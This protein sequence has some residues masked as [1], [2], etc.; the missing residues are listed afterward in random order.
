MSPFDLDDL[1]LQQDHLRRIARAIVGDAYADDVVQ[2]TWAAALARHDR[3]PGHWGSWLNRVT[4]NLAWK[5]RL[6]DERGAARARERAAE[7]PIEAEASD[8]VVAEIE[9]KHVVERAILGLDEPY[10]SVLLWRYYEGLSIEEVSRRAGTN[11]STTRTQLQRGLDRLRARLR[12]KRGPEWRLALVPFLRHEPVAAQATAATVLAGVWT[13]TWMKWSVASVVVAS[14]GVLLSVLSNGPLVPPD[15][16][17]PLVEPEASVLAA[18]DPS[19][20]ESAVVAPSEARDPIAAH[21]PPHERPVAAAAAPAATVEVVEAESGLPLAGVAVK[22]HHSV[23]ERRLFMARTRRV[24]T[25]VITDENGRATVPIELDAN[26]MSAGNSVHGTIPV[27]PR[28][29]FSVEC[30]SEGLGE[31]GSLRLVARAGIALRIRLPEDLADADAASITATVCMDFPRVGLGVVSSRIRPAAARRRELLLLVPEAHQRSDPLPGIVKLATTSTGPSF[32]AAFERLPGFAD[33]PLDATR[34]TDVT[35]TFVVV[36][37]DSGAPLEGV[38][39]MAGRGERR[40]AYGT[41]RAAGGSTDSDGEIE[42]IGV[43]GADALVVVREDGFEDLEF[44]APLAAGGTTEL[45]LR[46]LP[47]L[48]E[49]E[50]TVRPRGGAAPRVVWCKVVDDRG[51]SV[52]RSMAEIHGDREPWHAT[53]TIQNVP[54]RVAFLEIDVFPPLYDPIEPVRIEPGVTEL[55]VDLG[56]EVPLVH[57]VLDLPDD[58]NAEYRQGARGRQLG[59]Y[60]GRHSGTSPVTT[61]PDDGRSVFWIVDAPGYVPA[62]GTEEDWRRSSH[63]GRPCV[64]IAPRMERGWGALIRTVSLDLKD[65]L[66]FQFRTEVPIS[67]AT[68]VDPAT[69][70]TLGVTD[71]NGYAVVTAGSPLPRIEARYGGV[72]KSFRLGD[73]RGATLGF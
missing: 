53:D 23:M 33:S 13:M 68:I 60:R 1:K 59:T 4:H 70:K 43:P 7:R 54:P 11:P 37:H 61:A 58:A 26:G 18:V 19:R 73:A 63:Q 8:D 30:P 45:R 32:E 67:G 40:S 57:V 25:D 16:P 27:D 20:G 64:T 42:L 38:Y 49:V 48:R 72:T 52:H 12:S 36:D 2:D 3:P 51:E 66:P 41:E 62:Y 69:G 28:G 21:S 55:E 65:G 15:R 47:D 44:A 24:E 14:V 56:P 34:S 39:V 31:D 71:A 9:T 22:V 5:R 46:R 50:V 17:T 10:R 29:V 6:K 35:H